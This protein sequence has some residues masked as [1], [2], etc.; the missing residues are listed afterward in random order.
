MAYPKVTCPRCKGEGYMLGQHVEEQG[1]RVP[2]YRHNEDGLCFAC[3]NDRYLLRRPD[4]KLVRR[5]FENGNWL[6]YDEKGAFISVVDPILD[7]MGLE[8]ELLYDSFKAFEE[9]IAME[10]KEYE[11]K[12]YSK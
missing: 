4:G 6:W 8:Y 11:N 2:N 10:Y 12:N 5:D 9:E 3:D 7:D 1:V